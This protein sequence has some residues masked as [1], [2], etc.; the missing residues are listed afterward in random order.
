VLVRGP[1]AAQQPPE[2][3]SVEERLLAQRL[4]AGECAT[5]HGAAGLGGAVPGTD[6]RAPAIGGDNPVTVAYADL[7]LRTGRMPPAGTP[8]DNRAREVAYDDATIEVLVAWMAEE[9]D[10]P[11]DLPQPPPGNAGRGLAVWA[12]N[13]SQCHGAT[14]A[15][16]VAGAGAW[17]P[18]VYDKEPI[19]IAEA[20]RVG[21]FEMPAFSR[22]Q[23]TDQEVGDV[24]A[25]MEEIREDEG[26]PLLGIV[27][28]NP[29]YA[30]AFVALLSLLI[31]IA[32][33]IIAG[34]PAWFPDPEQAD[35]STRDASAG[36]SSKDQ[37]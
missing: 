11:G 13:C 28:L 14:G 32:V 16:G 19:V 1:A 5:C 7:V 8:F 9:F 34:K 20:I 23:I 2:E 22:E 12:A 24:A 33:V 3:L 18:S 31:L 25:F 6:G 29:V 17:T 15:G 35:R 21:P 10:L 36:R 26:T 27:E 37:P 30:S 4:Y